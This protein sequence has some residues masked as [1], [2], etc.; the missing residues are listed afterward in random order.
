MDQ[1]LHAGSCYSFFMMEERVEYDYVGTNQN[2]RVRYEQR[3]CK[4]PVYMVPNPEML[5]KENEYEAI[6][7]NTLE[8]TDTN[9]STNSARVTTSKD[10]IVRHIGKRRGCIVICILMTVIA[11]ITFV[12]LVIG[13]LSLRGNS[14]T[15]MASAQSQDYNNLSMIEELNAL[16]SLISQL[17]L[18]TQ[19]NISQLHHRLSLSGYLFSVSASRLSTSVY[20][21]SSSINRLSTSVYTASSRVVSNSI[22]IS[23]LSASASQL[24]T[25]L[26]T[27]SS[28]NSITISRLSTS[29]SQLSTSLHSASSRNSITISRLSASASQLSMS[30]RTA[31]SSAYWNSFTISRLSTSATRLS[32]SLSTASS[33][34]YWNSY[35]ISRVSSFTISSLSSSVLRLSTSLALCQNC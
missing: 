30:L 9:Q 17:N 29:A 2:L 35:S 14:T 25:S 23:R 12:A 19:Q 7:T 31:S 15:Q 28:R 18:E 20:S 21:A 32:T 34:A 5:D 4:S 26:R 8:S 33:R 3:G 13:A 22:T 6:Q 1:L 16:K 11:M 27:A 10:D 24:S